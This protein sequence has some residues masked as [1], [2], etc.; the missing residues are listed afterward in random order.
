M[1]KVASLIIYLTSVFRAIELHRDH[2]TDRTILTPVSL[3]MVTRAATEYRENPLMIA[4]R[5]ACDLDISI[6]LALSKHAKN[7]GVSS[8]TLL[9]LWEDTQNVISAVGVHGSLGP[10]ECPPWPVFKEAI[11][12]L[13]DQGLLVASDR[14]SVVPIGTFNPDDRT[15][16]QTNLSY[17]DVLVALRDGKNKMVKEL[18]PMINEEQDL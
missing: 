1:P 10:L 6:F 14:P 15:K 12:R 18:F 13:L 17:N 11:C 4:T 16:Y 5:Y 9:E 2:Q 3:P 7:T 8:L